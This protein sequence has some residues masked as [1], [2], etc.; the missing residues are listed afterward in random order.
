MHRTSS[1]ILFNEFFCF[2]RYLL[3]SSFLQVVSSLEYV[4]ALLTF[5]HDTYIALVAYQSQDRLSA[6]EQYMAQST[7]TICR[8]RHRLLVSPD[9]LTSQFHRWRL[10][11]LSV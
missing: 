6:R 11:K 4:F 7:Q 1:A 5:F 8:M 9:Q 10:H 3:V 2:F